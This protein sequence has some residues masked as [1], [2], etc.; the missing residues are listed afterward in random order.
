MIFSHSPFWGGV[1]AVILYQSVITNPT[2]FIS[3]GLGIAIGFGLSLYVTGLLAIRGY[4]NVAEQ[5]GDALMDALT[6]HPMIVSVFADYIINLLKVM[7]ISHPGRPMDS[8]SAC[9]V[10]HA[11]APCDVTTSTPS[12]CPSSPTPEINVNI[13]DIQNLLGG[14]NIQDMM[15]TLNIDRVPNTDSNEPNTDETPV[16]KPD[17]GTNSDAAASETC[18]R[19]AG[20]DEVSE[21]CSDADGSHP[22][23][24]EETPREDAKE[25]KSN[26][27]NPRSSSPGHSALP[28]ST[29]KA[30]M[31]R[32]NESKPS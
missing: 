24:K 20:S 18:Q 10:R 7:G 17:C 26:P 1:L 21:S 6:M 13:E 2:S 25:E 15:R 29:G 16:D 19:H 5:V 27:F 28:R 4:I 31:S 9:P 11:Q 8:F 12:R 3:L 14:I 32:T 23:N 30:L 22:V